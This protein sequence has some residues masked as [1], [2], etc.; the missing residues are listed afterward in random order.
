MCKITTSY[1]F[2][3]QDIEILKSHVTVSHEETFDSAPEPLGD[4]TDSLKDIRVAY[5][6]FSAR[7]T[8]EM[9]R[10]YK[11]NV[12]TK[13]HKQEKHP[14]TVS[15]NRPRLSFLDR[16]FASTSE[17]IAAGDNYIENRR[18]GNPKANAKLDYR[19]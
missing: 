14:S 11:K 10:L 19:D 6:Q 1:I 4:L 7:N 2:P 15:S 16:R 3:I 12:R 13:I 8:S 9:E 18:Y 5:E 17:S